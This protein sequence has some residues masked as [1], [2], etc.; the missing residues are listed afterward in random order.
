MEPEPAEAT[1]ALPLYQEQPQGYDEYGRPLPPA[2]PQQYGGQQQFA[3]PAGYGQPA[4]AA[5]DSDYD[6]L[7]RNDVPGPEP[8]RPR[9][10]QPHAQEPQQQWQQQPGYEGGGYEGH[11][12][13]YDDRYDDEDGGRRRMS[14]KVLVGIV[15]AGCVVAGLVVGGLMN[16]G[17]KADADNAGSSSPTASA[18]ASGKAPAAGGGQKDDAA[19]GAEAQ[20]KA[21][22]ALLA[23]S[24]ASRSSVVSA[25]ES[26]KGCKNLAGAAADLRAAAAQRD[27]LVTKLG[28]LSV[29]KLPDH[30]RLTTAL[31]KAWNAS[32]AADGHY[33]KWAEQA[34][35]N[36]SVCKGGHARSTAETQAGNRESGTATTEKKTAVKLWNSIAAKYDLTKRKYSQL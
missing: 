24:N 14:P 1:Q 35:N 9:I 15:V 5:P 20:A 2:Q 21:L 3:D 30:E 10:L 28:T 33:A 6:H 25:V 17:G 11:N 36:H 34:A 16:S 8:M 18:S 7:F 29:D 23:S 22:D 12:G 27:G 32:S 13:G 4:P 19:D 26:I 31:T